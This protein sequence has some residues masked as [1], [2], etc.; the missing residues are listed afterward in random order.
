MPRGFLHSIVVLMYKVGDLMASWRIMVHADVMATLHS[1][2]SCFVGSSPSACAWLKPVCQFEGLAD[3][4]ARAVQ[5]SAWWHSIRTE[6]HSA[7]DG[8]TTPEMG[9]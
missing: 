9:P 1:L 4:G 3:E 2:G 7:G 6:P 5:D 8:S